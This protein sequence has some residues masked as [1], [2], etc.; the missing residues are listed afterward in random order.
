MADPVYVEVPANGNCFFYSFLVAAK[1]G[2]AKDP[3]VQKLLQW[4]VDPKSLP[5]DLTSKKYVDMLAKPAALLRQQAGNFIE[6]RLKT[7]AKDEEALNLLETNHNELED[8]GLDDSPE[9][10]QLIQ[11]SEMIRRMKAAI[12]DHNE[13]VEGKIAYTMESYEKNKERAAKALDLVLQDGSSVAQADFN[14]WVDAMK[15]NVADIAKWSKLK[16][17]CEL[18]GFNRNEIPAMLKYV[19]RIK[20]DINYAGYPEA[21]ALSTLYGVPVTIYDQN[22]DAPIELNPDSTKKPI[23]LEY[24][25]NHFTAIV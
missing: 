25:R 10:R 5:N 19:D 3:G 14:K 20:T 24:D 12:S 23:T 9:N 22:N 18:G 16:I 7:L 11:T 8:L 13:M 15:L 6:E 2:Y 4:D 1:K 17:D 21:W